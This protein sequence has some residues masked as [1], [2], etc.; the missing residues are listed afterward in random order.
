MNRVPKPMR[1]TLSVTAAFARTWGGLK[2]IKVERL[3][4][5]AIFVPGQCLRNAESACVGGV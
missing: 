5:T 4:F 2:L 1:P 3:K